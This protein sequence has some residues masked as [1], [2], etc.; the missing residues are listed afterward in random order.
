MT[1]DK[2][3]VDADGFIDFD[4][5]APDWV[6]PTDPANFTAEEIARI[7]SAPDEAAE[8]EAKLAAK[9]RDLPIDVRLLGY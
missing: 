3:I 4:A 8:I 7:N 6:D 1:S 2:D 5:L 9:W